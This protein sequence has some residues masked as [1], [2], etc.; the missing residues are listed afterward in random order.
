MAKADT[1]NLVGPCVVKLTADG[2]AYTD[3]ASSASDYTGLQWTQS[4]GSATDTTTRI[5]WLPAEEKEKNMRGL[6]EVI[7]IDGET[8]ELQKVDG[9]IRSL[10][11]AKDEA[12]AKLKI[13]S[14]AALVKDLDEYD[15]IVKRLGDV[16]PKREVQEVKIAKD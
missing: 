14:K 8:G 2:T 9:I 7:I 3:W 4:V 16:R 1:L 12:S 10:V 6:F 5:T 11:V 13:V 15:I